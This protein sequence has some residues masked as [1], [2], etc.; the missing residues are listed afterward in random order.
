MQWFQKYDLC[1]L[2]V[3]LNIF[4]PTTYR[5]GAN[6]LVVGDSLGNVI[7]IKPTPREFFFKFFDRV[8]EGSSRFHHILSINIS[9]NSS[10]MLISRCDG[11]IF[12]F[13]E[14]KEVISMVEVLEDLE[15]A[16][17]A[18]KIP[19]KVSKSTQ[20][21]A[22]NAG[23]RET[24][25]ATD[26]HNEDLDDTNESSKKVRAVDQT[27]LFQLHADL[28]LRSLGATPIQCCSISDVGV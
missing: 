11:A 7:V 22:I 4:N 15:H 17:Q 10:Y 24:G 25:D 14:F 18:K 23:S 6:Y 2:I 5:D 12:V 20:K 28:N 19:K 16:S 13:K 21:S 9:P 26:A 27:K 1:S 3:V 8:L